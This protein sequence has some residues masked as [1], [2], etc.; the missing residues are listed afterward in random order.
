[1]CKICGQFQET[2]AAHLHWTVCKHYN[3]KV[4]DKHYEH[5]PAYVTENQTVTI[6]RDMPIQTDKEIK[7]NR[8][9]IVVKDKKERICLLIDVSIPTGRNTSLKTMEKL[10]RYK[11][12]EIEIEKMWGNENN[13][14]LSG[15]W[16]FRARQEGN[17]KLHRQDPRKYQN[18]RATEDRSPWNCSHTQEDPIHQVIQ[19][20]YD[21]PRFMD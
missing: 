1:M 9:D 21:C 17:I 8:P 15:Q 13:N 2:A 20:T 7:A 3:V 6:L 11:D 14:C 18:N 19:Q 16:G 4:Q 10:T 12:L 5:E